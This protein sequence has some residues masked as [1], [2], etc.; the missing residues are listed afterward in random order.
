MQMASATIIPTCVLH[1]LDSM[2]NGGTPYRAYL[3]NMRIYYWLPCRRPQLL[4]P[5]VEKKSLGL[6]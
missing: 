3:C 1:S 6:I 5:K 4:Q 2:L